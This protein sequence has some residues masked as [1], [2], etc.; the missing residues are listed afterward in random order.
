ME[1][2]ET[3]TFS[4]EQVGWT[5]AKAFVLVVLLAAMIQSTT[6]VVFTA[7]KSGA[8]T[9]ISARIQPERTVTLNV[10]FAATVVT[11]MRRE[12]DHVTAGETLMELESEELR[13]LLESA[14]R[15]VEIAGG[16]L[17][18]IGGYAS[19]SSYERAQERS[20]VQ[21]V[22]AAKR[23]LAAYSIGESETAYNSAKL[24]RSRVADLVDKQLATG[25]ELEA[26]RREEVNEQR[27]WK[28][29]NETLERLK[30]D[31][32]NALSHQKLVELQAS[33]PSSEG[34]PLA[35][36]ELDNAGRDLELLQRREASLR[37]TAPFDGV[38]LSGLPS[39]GERMD[40]GVPLAR[41]ADISRLRVVANV[42]S[43]IARD[44]RPGV[45]VQVRLPGDPP[46]TA[47]GVVVSNAPAAE[48]NDGTYVVRVSVDG[49]PHSSKLSGGDGAIEI[50]HEEK[51]W[52]F[53]F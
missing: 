36:L 17:K 45:N 30:D 31:L 40:A 22:T 15:R 25:A 41:V 10:S 49:L 32:D 39:A 37:V 34:S 51:P 23:R 44:L 7:G 35:R 33:G 38:L 42:A 52:R 26:A 12:G 11:V 48:Q 24:R 14:K 50:L 3:S 8:K 47:S 53:R 9:L 16:R 1:S 5:V 4:V 28:A 18:A 46:T 13:L 21:L 20:A 43:E 27:N 6:Q 29:A 19:K 2:R